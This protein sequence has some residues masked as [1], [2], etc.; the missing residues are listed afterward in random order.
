MLGGD[1]DI[2]FSENLRDPVNADP[3]P[4]RFQDLRLELSQGFDLGRFA[5]S[6]A[7]RAARKLDQISGSGF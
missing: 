1:I 5:V 2:P 4:M 7:F 6:A 3:A